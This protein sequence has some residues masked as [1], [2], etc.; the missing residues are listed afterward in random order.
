MARHFA[1]T[2]AL[3]AGALSIG[4]SLAGAQDRA[5]PTWSRLIVNVGFSAFGGV[6]GYDTY[7]RLIARHIGKYL[8]GNPV[9]TVA[10]KPGAG[11]LT[12]M[13]YM[14]NVAPHDGSE[15]AMVGRGN[16]MD[17]MLVGRQSTARFEATKFAWIGSMNKEVSVFAAMQ[18]TPLVLKDILDGK[19]VAVGV[20]GAGSD[21]YAYALM[22][23]RLLGTKLNIIPGY[24]GMNE[25]ELAMENGELVGVTGVSWDSLRVDKAE[26][27][28]SG[29]VKVLMQYAL[30][31]SPDL[32]DVP[33][34][35]ELVKDERDRKVIELV[36]SRQV[37]GRPLLA[38]PGLAPE[39]VAL[40]R[41]AYQKAMADPELL[42]E[43]KKMQL[44]LRTVPGEQIQALMEETSKA[45][46]D[47]IRRAQD[48]FMEQ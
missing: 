24:P 9:V 33:L 6:G 27:L 36:L 29:K 7:A 34:L 4:L 37:M 20:P 32:P 30:E 48:I 18:A 8:P 15:I 14:Y 31:R 45:S 39:R 21:P 46:P 43:A 44:E 10:N 38:P 16:A 17:P 5:Q 11:G 25:V 41:Q 28:R 42:E 23:N 40:L 12:V 3:A 22:M 1:G 35:G 2:A 26:W 47:V 13:N 19:T